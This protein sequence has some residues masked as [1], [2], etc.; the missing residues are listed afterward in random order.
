MEKGRARRNLVRVAYERSKISDYM[1]GAFEKGCMN[2]YLANAIAGNPSTALILWPERGTLVPCGRFSEVEG[3]WTL[4]E[5]DACK[6][7][8][9]MLN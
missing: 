7:R 3:W 1:S 5:E 4:E 2:F 6:K 9:E 8:K